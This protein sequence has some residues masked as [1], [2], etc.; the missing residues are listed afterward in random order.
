M[1]H[2]LKDVEQMEWSPVETDAACSLYFLEPHHGQVGIRA[3]HG[4]PE[5]D[6]I[7]RHRN[8]SCAKE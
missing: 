3:A 7:S 5:V 2:F 4:E 8:T 1:F 6:M